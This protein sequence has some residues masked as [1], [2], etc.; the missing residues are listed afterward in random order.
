M[1]F[2]HDSSVIIFCKICESVFLFCKISEV[3]LFTLYGTV[4]LFLQIGDTDSPR[5]SPGTG[6][7]DNTSVS[8]RHFHMQLLSN[9]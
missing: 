1:M 8:I 5:F 9:W 3:F 4:F 2:L 7:L 6:E